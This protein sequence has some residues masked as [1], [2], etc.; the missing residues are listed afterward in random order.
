MLETTKGRHSIGR[1]I[2]RSYKQR[3]LKCEQAAKL[4]VEF[5]PLE[6]EVLSLSD[7]NADKQSYF[8]CPFCVL[9]N[10]N[11]EHTDKNDS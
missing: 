10:G 7:D 1:F 3:T 9:S 11:S 4:A 8:L 2:S 6:N 5:Q